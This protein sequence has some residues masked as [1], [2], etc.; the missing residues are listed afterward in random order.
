MALFLIIL[1]YTAA[2]SVRYMPKQAEYRM[3][4]TSSITSEF[5]FPVCLRPDC[6]E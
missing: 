5:Q 2:F 6:S 4:A 1:Y 3:T